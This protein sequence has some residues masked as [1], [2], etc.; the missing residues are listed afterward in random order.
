[1]I[2]NESK[3]IYIKIRVSEAEEKQIKRNAA[4]CDQTVSAYVR[5]SALNMCVVPIDL[6]IVTKNSE[7]IEAYR[8]TIT[9]LVYTIKRTG[10]YAPA[11]LEYILEKTNQL[12]KNQKSFLELYATH[13]EKDIKK[14]GTSVKNI[15]SR[16]L[17]KSSQTNSKDDSD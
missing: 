8:N 13:V 11:D 4:A 16:R 2:D 6:D 15:V 12:L 10:N 17:N 5:E 7:E 9:Q 3:K 1:M 14:V